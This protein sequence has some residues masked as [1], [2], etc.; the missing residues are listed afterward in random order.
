MTGGTM[1]MNIR[2]IIIDS[3][4]LAIRGFELTDPVL[5]IFGDS[6]S[7]NLMCPWVVEGPSVSFSWVRGHRG[8]SVGAGWS[9]DHG[10]DLGARSC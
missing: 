10:T 8:S 3:L 4:P 1:G 5:T 7:L 9:S 2:A 6:W